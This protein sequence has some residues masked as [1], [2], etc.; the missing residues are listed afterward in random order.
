[1]IIELLFECCAGQCSHVM[2]THVAVADVGDYVVGVTPSPQPPLDFYH[3][4]V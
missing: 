4:S 3:S 1:M 2:V